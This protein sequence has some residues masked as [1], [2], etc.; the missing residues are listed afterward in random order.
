VGKEIV[1]L[2]N[3]L[4]VFA[5]ADWRTG[6]ALMEFG[7]HALELAAKAARAGYDLV[8]AYGGDGTLNQVLN[9]VVAARGRTRTIGVIPGGTANVWAR[10]IGLPA[11]PVK[12]ALG[13]VGSKG[14]SVDIGY[15][16][17]SR[18]PSR[19]GWCG[20]SIPGAITS[21]SWPAWEWTQ[22]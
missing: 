1:R 13:L 15:V 7:D 17:G 14:R 20:P 5:A 16:E 21:S 18:S 3:V 2:R 19:I 10:E 9:G 22:P 8:L 4:G 12:A 6:V 11:D